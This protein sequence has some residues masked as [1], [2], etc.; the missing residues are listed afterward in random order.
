MPLPMVHLAVAKK[1]I[2]DFD[3][4]N[5]LSMFYL[6]AIAPD[7]IHMRENPVGED[8]PKSHLYSRDIR[9]IQNVYNYYSKK[10]NSTDSDFFLGYCVHLL[11]DIYWHET[12]YRTFENR[13]SKDNEPIQDKRWAYYNDTDKLDFE[14]FRILEWKDEVWTL[15]NKA[16][17]INVDDLVTGPEIDAWNE[18]TLNWYNC[19]ESEHK[20]PIKY[21]TL[22]D[23]MEFIDYSSNEILKWLYLIN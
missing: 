7:A 12:L 8:K 18:R 5:N 14:L 15:L 13:Y 10:S 23:L 11:T 21:I 16:K 20:N 4:I 2:N 22:D 3:R 17:G 1:I 19:G 9:G 6:G